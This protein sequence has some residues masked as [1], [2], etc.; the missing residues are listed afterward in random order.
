[1][2][3]ELS[4]VLMGTILILTPIAG[5]AGKP[6]ET[7]P[8]ARVSVRVYDQ[9]GLESKT[10]EKAKKTAE[11]PFRLAGV[12]I[13][14][15]HCS[16]DGTETKAV[17]TSLLGPNEI[18][19]RIVSRSPAERKATG[20]STGG[21]ATRLSRVGGAGLIALFFDRLDTIAREVRMSRAVVLG[22][23]MTHEIGHLLLPK[24]SH[25]RRGIMRAKLGR[26]DWQRASQGTLLFSKKQAKQIF[27]GVW[28]RQERMEL[29]ETAQVAANN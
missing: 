1:M 12:E 11:R 28:G 27:S 9:A 17:C 8:H 14:W 24:Y 7:G 20:H 26:D 5:W 23:A 3:K 16:V 4:K 22:Q 10:L 25:S 2:K 15:V 18:S 13:D 6:A 19:L 29:A 21:R